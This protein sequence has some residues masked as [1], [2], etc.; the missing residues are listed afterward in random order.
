MSPRL[1]LYGTVHRGIRHALL[2][3]QARLGQLDPADAAAVRALCAQLRDVQ[4]ICAVHLEDED[5]FVHPA[6]EARAPHASL[7]VQ[8][9]HVHHRESLAHL[10]VLTDALER[11]PTHAARRALERTLDPFIAD[12]LE[13]M[14]LEED[15]LMPLLHATWSDQELKALLDRLL[16]HIA[17]EDMQRF[18]RWMLT[19]LPHDWRVAW[20]DGVR[21]EAPPQAFTQML[22]LAR[23]VLPA[24]AFASMELALSGDVLQPQRA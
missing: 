16:A 13:H 19:G 11:E 3:T 6:I 8:H 22:G 2:D 1:D 9:D 21:R 4:R 12:S 10:R 17:P 18:T 20:L 15:V 23:E 14:R 24:P 7:A 5:R